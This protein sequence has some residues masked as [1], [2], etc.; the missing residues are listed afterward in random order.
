MRTITKSLVLRLPRDTA[1]HPGP[2]LPLLRFLQPLPAGQTR[3]RENWESTVYWVLGATVFMA[4]AGSYR[5]D[6]NP[7]HWAKDEAAERMRRREVRRLGAVACG[8]NC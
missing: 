4:I 8:C 2:D 7:R 3:A 1:V 5:P 6:T